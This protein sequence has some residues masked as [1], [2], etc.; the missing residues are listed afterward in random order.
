MWGI[1]MFDLWRVGYGIEMFDLK[2]VG[3][4][5]QRMLNR[6]RMQKLGDHAS[7]F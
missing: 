3:I 6:F 7:L 2:R 4:I 1:L 5:G